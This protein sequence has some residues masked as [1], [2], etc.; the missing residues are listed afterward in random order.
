LRRMRSLAG[1]R[2]PPLVPNR[3]RPAC[4]WPQCRI[5]VLDNWGGVASHAAA[6]DLPDLHSVGRPCGRTRR[7]LRKRGDSGRADRE[8]FADRGKHAVK[9]DHSTGWVWRWGLYFWARLPLVT[10]RNGR[11]TPAAASV[12]SGLGPSQR[13]TRIIRM[14]RSTDDLN[15]SERSRAI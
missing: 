5:E 14:D 1:R 11:L 4:G 8:G 13:R 3:S 6:R 10:C 12:P 7:T 9:R 15:N 2:L